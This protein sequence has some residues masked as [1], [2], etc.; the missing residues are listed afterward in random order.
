[1]KA[2][3]R[4]RAAPV[5]QPRLR[6]KIG[7]LVALGPGKADLL[8]RIADTGS[9]RQAAILMQMSYMRAWSLVKIINHSFKQP[10]VETDRGG[11]SKGGARLTET[12]KRVLT[13]YRRMENRSRAAAETNWQKLK[14][15]LKN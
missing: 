14:L 13:L 8:E 15:L 3:T 12:G 2:K 9:I 5:L 1:M 10:A 7:K 11:N 4:K 6:I